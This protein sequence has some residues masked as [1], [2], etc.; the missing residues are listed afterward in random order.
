MAHRA[1]R[2]TRSPVFLIALLGALLFLVRGYHDEHEALHFRDFKQPYSSARCLLAHC[3]PYSESDTRT[4]YIAAGGVN[5]DKVVF[6]PYSALYPPFSLVALMPVAAL[7]YPVAHAVW[8]ALIGVGFAA[9]VLL[10][11][12]M[13]LTVGT[14]IPLA[15]V[16]AIF[17]FSS[18][19]LLMLG[20]I[21][22]LVI[23]LLV[24][25][26]ACVF[27]ERFPLT[28]VLCFSIAV[29]LKPHDAAI[30]LV[31][32]LFA[33][34]RARLVFAG[35]AILSLLVAAGSLL[36]FAHN[37]HTAH[38]LGELRAN[39]KGNAAPGS[40]NSPTLG[41]MQGTNLA[42]L[43][44]VFAV[45]RPSPPF[46][47]GAALLVSALLLGV[48]TVPA[49]RLRPGLG[50]HYLATGAIACLA[51]LP[52]YHRQYDTRMLLLV[53]PAIAFLL[54]EPR[55]RR[56]GLAGFA[57]LS[58]ATVLTAHQFL[59]HVL[60]RHEQAV[61]QAGI[62]QTLLLFRPIPWAVSALLVLL[63]GAMYRM[64]RDQKT[65]EV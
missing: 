31:Y 14:S 11:A 65:S 33:G 34:P 12:Q 45:L 18:T 51:L 20:Q 49:M 52:I 64:M 59:D 1:T 13:C 5:D 2:L 27:R 17:A 19:I 38:W 53:F 10:A 32:L 8:E 55:M 26:Y 9:A 3:D 63:L 58:A 7:P 39:L 61:A 36:A 6:D 48:W 44:A 60:H 21:S 4:A 37:P 30:P 23:A 46:Y 50:K 43:E 42:D 56:W 25:G 47:N 40:V 28:A 62:A 54:G 29:L 24:L 35:T 15:G 41:H 22:G 57:L 16:L